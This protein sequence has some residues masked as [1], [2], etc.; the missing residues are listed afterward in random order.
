M[1]SSPVPSASAH[2][3]VFGRDER[4]VLLDEVQFKWL[5]A[6]LGLWVDMARFH[7]EAS[8]ANHFLE[9]AEVSDSPVLRHSAAA[10]RHQGTQTSH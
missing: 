2:A 10:L 4:H 7:S 8:Y 6:G 3:A 9:L 1:P 5:L